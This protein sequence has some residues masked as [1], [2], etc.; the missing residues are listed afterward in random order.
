MTINFDFKSDD[1]FSDHNYALIPM[2]GLDRHG[3]MSD[4]AIQKNFGKLKTA[5][6][7]KIF[8]PILFGVLCCIVTA[9]FVVYWRKLKSKRK[10][11]TYH[12]SNNVSEKR[13]LAT[14]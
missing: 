9:I 2:V 1:L 3:G 5:K 12:G 13:L 6:D 11:G 14:D 7:L 8:L 10:N 4:D